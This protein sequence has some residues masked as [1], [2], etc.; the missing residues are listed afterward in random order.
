MRNPIPFLDLHAV[1]ASLREQ[2][3]AAIA[4][5]IDSGHFI[6]G[7]N[8]AR[9]EEEFGDFCGASASSAFT[10]STAEGSP[11]ETLESPPRAKSRGGRKRAVGVAS[12]TDALAL[13]LK[14]LG[15]DEGDEVILPCWTYTATAAAV[16]YVGA[17]PVFVD[18]APGEFLL[19]LNQVSDRIS[20]R[21]RALLPVHLY[22]EMV[23]MEP[24]AALATERGLVVVEDVAQAAGATRNGKTAG[25]IGDAGC[26]SFYPTKPLG[27]CGEGGL[28]L[29]RDAAVE[30][31]IRHLR[32]QADDSI[33]GG[34]KYHH[35]AIGYNSRLQEIQAAILRVKLRHLK[36][37]NLRR[38]AA[39][40]LYLELLADVP[41]ALPQVSGVE[42]QESRVKRSGFD[43]GLSTL[44]PGHIYSLF[45]I[46]TPHR[47]ALAAWLKERDIASGVYYP[48]PLHLQEAYHFLGHKKGDFPVAEAH[49]E[50][51]LSLP[52][53][54]SMTEEQIAQVAEAIR[55]FFKK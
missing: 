6:L 18:C 38:Q 11:L 35:S 27:A 48:L 13:A 53:F 37:W 47:D 21:T 36:E 52:I 4:G 29:A 15:V 42:G 24:L 54:P 16:C 49:A 30:K 46:R 25:T 41:L 22:G 10:L 8:V 9:F 34:K 14:A 3:L 43:S 44:D 17:K 7:E 51:V 55:E 19:D 20:P 32:A 1:H 40:G 5:V 39:A 2:I 26:F 23:D 31:K 33:I 50:Q 45:T 28:I 12:G